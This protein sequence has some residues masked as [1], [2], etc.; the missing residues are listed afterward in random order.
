MQY[1]FEVL[2]TKGAK[3]DL[4][5]IVEYIKRDNLS[6]AKKVFD[7]IKDKVSQLHHFPNRWRI[8]LELKEIG[9]NNYRELIIDRWRV[10]YK[11][12]EKR[13]YIVSVIDSRQNIEDILFQ[14]FFNK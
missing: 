9:V 11:I 12:V 6:N 13:I 10:I 4:I 7:K 3:R 14:R 1:D 5:L 8:V 2:W